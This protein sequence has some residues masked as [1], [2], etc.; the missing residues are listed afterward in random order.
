MNRIDRLNAIL[1]QLQGKPRVV[2][3][4]L[5]DRFEVSPRTIF[6]DIKSLIETGVPIGG[7]AGNG[8]FIV[9]GFHLPPVVFNKQEA[10]ALLMG[11][12]LIKHQADKEIVRNFDEAMHKVRAVLRYMDKDFLDSLDENISVAP[13]ARAS[14]EFPDSHIAIIQ[15][16]LADQKLLKI[17]Y[18]SN[19]KD[20]STIREVEPL[21]LVYYTGR[22]HLIAYCRLRKDMRDF[23]CDRISKCEPLIEEYDRSK[24]PKFAEFIN[25]MVTG[26]ES[27]EA[28]IQIDK[29]V[30]RHI[31]S[32]KYY[33]GFAEEKDLGEKVELKFYTSHLNFF[34]RWLLMFGKE[35]KIISPA[36][37]KLEMENLVEELKQ[38]YQ[39]LTEVITS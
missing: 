27:Q 2:I 30:N 35:V 9:E 20:Q 24:H 37:L 25:Q 10:A 15:N 34:A 16:A 28:I 29:K 5:V 7:D 39:K 17:K 31:G 32:Q 26:T 36:A 6:R 14:M 12:K 23:R 13:F 22:W 4:D 8:Y 19:Y 33:Y 18:H 1:I 11:S 38:H 3:D 21:G